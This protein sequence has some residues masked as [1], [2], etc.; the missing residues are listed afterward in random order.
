MKSMVMILLLVALIGCTLGEKSAGKGVITETTNVAL[1]RGTIF[2]YDSSRLEHTLIQ[3]FRADSVPAAWEGVAFALDTT[4]ALGE[5]SIGHLFEAEYQAVAISADSQWMGQVYFNVVADVDTI[6][7]LRIQLS[8]KD[9]LVGVFENYYSIVD[10][11]PQGK[12]LRANMKGLGHVVSLDSTGAYMFPN[13]PKGQHF[14]RIQLVDGIPTHEV[15]LWEDWIM[16]E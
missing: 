15:T 11:L 2:L 5:W 6:I 13:V 3:V 4:N 10:T 9:T 1:A 12:Y 16:V 14:V 8:P 7:D